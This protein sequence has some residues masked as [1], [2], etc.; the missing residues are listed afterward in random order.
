[1][2]SS[3]TSTCST[4]LQK[5]RQ[6]ILGVAAL[7][8][9]SL[10]L[11]KALQAQSLTAQ[12]LQS[13]SPSQVEAIVNGFLQGAEPSTA[14]LKI[15]MPVLGDNPAAVPVK[16]IFETPIDAEQYCEELIVVAAGN[17]IPLACRFRFT[18]LAGTTEVAIRLR[19][20]QSQTIKALARMND[21]RYLV[22]QQAIT[23]TA[24][25]CGM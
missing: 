9:G 22:A 19:L 23:V 16:V 15:E 11:P 5:R 21:G 10:A 17:P 2:I 7:G 13:A 1:M 25:G 6:I 18:P 3:N 20:I 24:G 14:G 8:V 12:P 4:L